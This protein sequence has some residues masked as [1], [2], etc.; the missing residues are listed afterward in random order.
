MAKWLYAHYGMELGGH[1]EETV[2]YF[3]FGSNLHAST[4]LERRKMRPT[5]TRVGCLRGYRLRFNLDGR[6]LGKAAPANIEPDVTAEV[7]GVL[8]QIT[9][10]ELVRL[11]ST[12]G[13]PGGRYRHLWADTEDSNGRSVHAITYMAPGN[14]VDGNPSLRY[15]TLLREGA[16]MHG[17]PAWWVDYLESVQHA[18]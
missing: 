14:P 18:E 12:E 7:W 3:A 5:E 13:V 8:Y 9:R 15:I 2:W 1:P 11:D 4:F 10:R 17:L 16:R 6:P